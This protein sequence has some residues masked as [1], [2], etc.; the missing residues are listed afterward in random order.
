MIKKILLGLMLFM[1]AAVHVANAE[2]ITLIDGKLS[3]DIPSGFTSLS[4]QEIQ[5][6]YPNGN[7][8]TAA[9]GNANRSFSI[10]ITYSVQI[11]T[12]DKLAELKGV[13]TKT[14]DRVIP[15]I[16]WKVNEIV[17]I[18]GKKWV[19]FEMMSNAID[20]DIHN[21]M[22]ITDLGGRMLGVNFNAPRSTYPQIQS[23]F[24]EV[25]NSIKVIE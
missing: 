9:Y 4:E 19:H 15:G 1:C 16:V 2:I 10:A 20:T 3:M 14:F 25:V 5:M 12:T 7:P 18:K 24:D 22:F 6:K 17:T 21:Q 23:A 8:P 11:L 13:L